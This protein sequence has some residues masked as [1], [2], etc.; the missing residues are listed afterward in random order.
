MSAVE[1]VQHDR[2]APVDSSLALDSSAPTGTCILVT[3][4]VSV[5]P[6]GSVTASDIPASVAE[7]ATVTAIASA[8]APV[9]DTRSDDTLPSEPIM[10]AQADAATMHAP[11]PAVGADQSPTSNLYGTALTRVTDGAMKSIE[12]VFESHGEYE[13]N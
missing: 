1:I 7:T 4:L 2:V 5:G 12:F 9:I 3:T 13:M 6:G 10:S 11:P 8:T